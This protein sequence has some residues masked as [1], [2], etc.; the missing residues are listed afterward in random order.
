MGIYIYIYIYKEKGKAAILAAVTGE[1]HLSV[2]EGKKKGKRHLNNGV[3]KS[4]DL[5]EYILNKIV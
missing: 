5:M 2:R 1:R 4:M 3:K